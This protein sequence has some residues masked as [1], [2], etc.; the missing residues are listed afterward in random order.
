MGVSFLILLAGIKML[1][2]V[3]KN[4]LSIIILIATFGCMLG[5]SLF[6]I[7]FSSIFYILIGGGCALIIYCSRLVVLKQKEKKQLKSLE[8]EPSNIT[9]KDIE[10]TSEEQ[11]EKVSKTVKK[12]NQKFDKFLSS[13]PS[14]G[15]KKEDNK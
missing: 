13:Q 14:S 1:K 4:V 3:K 10:K 5:F 12:E 15:D 9:Q 6:A 11:V 8:K 7:S 2:D